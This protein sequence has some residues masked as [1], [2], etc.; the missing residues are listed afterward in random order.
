M[1]MGRVVAP[2]RAF[3]RGPGALRWFAAEAAPQRC[4]R[5]GRLPVTNAAARDSAIRKPGARRRVRSGA[6]R[7]ECATLCAFSRRLI[8]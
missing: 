6:G 2:N 1:L 4:F 7:R 5:D 3:T 8:L